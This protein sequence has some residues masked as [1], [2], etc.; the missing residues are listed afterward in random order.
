MF[1]GF[2]EDGPGWALVGFVFEVRA[3]SCE[4]WRGSMPVTVV[5]RRN[6]CGGIA[7]MRRSMRV[8]RPERSV[9]KIA[10]VAGCR[11]QVARL[12]AVI[13]E[14]CLRSIATKA[15][16]TALTLRRRTSPPKTP[17]RSGAATRSRT[18]GPKWR[19][20]KSAT[21]SS[22]VGDGGAEFGGAGG[23]GAVGGDGCGREERGVIE[24]GEVGRHHHVEAVGHGDE[25]AGGILGSAEQ[26][27][28]LA[29]GV[30]R[31][32]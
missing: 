7:A 28:G 1:A 2:G 10:A 13:S 19:R 8:P 18:S 30:V 4:L 12:S 24:G 16:M 11:L 22:C 15:G 5:L 3:M 26:D 17:L 25:A 23:F 27:P 31:R 32:R 6:Q 14:P 29:G 9:V 20:V 21:V